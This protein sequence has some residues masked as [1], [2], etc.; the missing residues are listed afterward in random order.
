MTITVQQSSNAQ[1]CVNGD[2]MWWQSGELTVVRER[3]GA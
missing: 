1:Y 3:S 2:V